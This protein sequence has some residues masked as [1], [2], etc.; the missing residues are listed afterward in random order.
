MG[1]I[2]IAKWTSDWA[3]QTQTSYWFENTTTSTND[4]AKQEFLR[5]NEPLKLYVCGFQT[6]G[7]GRDN[8]T[9]VT[10]AENA[11]LLCSWSLAMVSPPQHISAPR[12]GLGLFQSAQQTWPQIDFNLK[13]PN[14]L[15]IGSKKVAGLLLESQSQGASHRLIVGIGFNV[16]S[17]PEQIP[18]STHLGEFHST[19]SELEWTQFLSA[20]KHEIIDAQKDCLHPHLGDGPRRRLLEALNKHPLLSE[21]YI[22]ISEH[23]DLVTGSG[24]VPWATL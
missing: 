5:I 9:W 8:N 12:L 14:D 20:L 11:S 1:E 2:N 4:V 17:H 16:A 10:P 19:L 23:A 21:P 7:R 18:E 22:D 3:S 15:Y 6:A 13:A 24:I